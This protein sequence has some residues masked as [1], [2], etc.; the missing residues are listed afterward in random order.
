RRPGG[1]RRF[2]LARNR[3][4]S[5]EEGVEPLAVARPAESRIPT[6]LPADHTVVVEIHERKGVRGTIHHARKPRLSPKGQ[7][8]LRAER[9]IS[10][11]L[12][13]CHALLDGPFLPEHIA[14]EFALEVLQIFAVGLSA[15]GLVKF[16]IGPQFADIAQGNSAL[17]GIAVPEEILVHLAA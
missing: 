3:A 8:L 5:G 12:F 1:P 16:R 14:F 15:S 4:E 17:N 7:A 6:K 9:L 10:G 13:S 11:R 2:R